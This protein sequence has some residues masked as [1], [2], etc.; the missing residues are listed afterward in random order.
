MELD[1]LGKIVG[2]FNSLGVSLA[3]I[4]PQAVKFNRAMQEEKNL[5]FEVLSDPGNKTAENYGIKYQLPNNLIKIYSQ[6]GIDLP[7]HNG[8]DTWTLPLPIRLII[9]PNGI[10]LDAEINADYTVRPEPED[11]LKKLRVLAD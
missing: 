4:S 11:T 9:D 7:K 8:D 6:F 5:T 1:A 3:A 2:E 10:I